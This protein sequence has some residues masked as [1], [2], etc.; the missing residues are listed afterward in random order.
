MRGPKRFGVH[1]W[2]ALMIGVAGLLQ[3]GCASYDSEVQTPRPLIGPQQYASTYKGDPGAPDPTNE[4]TEA[5]RIIGA[6]LAA[7]IQAGAVF[8]K[9]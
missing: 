5:G 2:L 7:G 4:P 6:I 8:S 1:G 9:N 3:G